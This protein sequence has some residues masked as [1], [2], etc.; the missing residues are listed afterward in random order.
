MGTSLRNRPSVIFGTLSA[1]ALAFGLAACG[2]NHSLAATGSAATDGAVST[3]LSDPAPCATATNGPFSHVYVTVTDVEAST[4]A[5]A[6]S[7]DGGWEDLTPN[8]KSAPQQ[9][10]L[11]GTASQSCLLAQ[12]GD[13]QELPP[14]AYQQVRLYLAAS[15]T[16]AITPSNACAAVATA[17]GQT[18]ANCVVLASGTVVN[19]DL[20]SEAKTGLKIPSGQIAGGK[21]VVAA[22]QTS[23][24]DIDFNSCA[25]IVAEGNGAYRLKPVLTAGEVTAAADAITGTLTNLPA[26]GKALV[27]LETTDGDGV[28]HVVMETTPDAQ[29]HF[30]FCP[31]GSGAYDVVADA[32][33]AENIADAATVVTGVSA[34]ETTGNMPLIAVAAPGTPA[35]ISGQIST[36]PVAAAG[37]DITVAALQPI[38]ETVNGQAAT[39]QIT[40]P[41][42]GAASPAA[43]ITTASAPSSGPACAAGTDCQ[44]YRLPVPAANA[45]VGAYAAGT[46][47][48]QQAPAAPPAYGVDALAPS[49]TAAGATAT[50]EQTTAETPAQ[51]PLT[52][53]AGQTSSAAGL[54]F[55]G[56]S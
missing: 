44:S 55:T 20:S 42:L 33:S 16:P 10:D 32:I 26:G 51:A 48:Y 31:V 41:L 43:S 29:G 19:L 49:C 15:A 3:S 23:D 37:E 22:G 18:S 25:S 46:I 47:V 35:I 27:A 38:T 52:V 17:S 12:L 14:G 30:V 2:G 50:A 24:L 54:H 1:L 34:G 56:C 36:A 39:V 7:G 53:T 28:D 6:A 40:V 21:F 9:I 4:S 45:S 5:T 8:L 11:L 13:A